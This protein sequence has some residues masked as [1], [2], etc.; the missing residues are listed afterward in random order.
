MADEHDPIRWKREAPAGLGESLISAGRVQAK[1]NLRGSVVTL[2][3]QCGVCLGE[4]WSV[5]VEVAQL[6]AFRRRKNV[7]VS[8]PM[9][10]GCGVKHKNAPA[11]TT[12][13]GREF[14]VIVSAN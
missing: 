14:T 13:C 6:R 10:C 3:V 11:D 9:T 4:P 7:D 5:D 12:G 8:V 2:T 1:E